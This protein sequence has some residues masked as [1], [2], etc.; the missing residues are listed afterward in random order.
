P[1]F[2][3]NCA[4][5]PSELV[6]S[7]LFGYERG[8]F[9]G[10][11]QSKPGMFALADGATLMLDEIGDM[12][13]NLQAKLLQVLQDQ[14]FRPLGAREFVRVDVR[15]IAATHC[16]L[17]AA[18]R[19]GRFREDL[20]YRLSVVILRVP[21]LRERQGEILE[22]A[23]YFLHK[24]AR[25]GMPAPKIGPVLAGALL[26]HHWPGNIRELENLMRRYLIFEDQERLAADLKVAAGAEAVRPAESLKIPPPAPP[27]SSALEGIEEA[28]SQAARQTILATLGS[29]RWN[30]KK[31]ARL[32]GVD[33]KALLYKM[34]KL[35]IVQPGPVVMFPETGKAGEQLD[36]AS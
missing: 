12:D 21:P 24:H 3:L 6:E 27:S 15:V 13:F 5:L 35:G 33:Y 9:T 26:D 19:Q 29:V 7:E 14:E 1:F 34:R 30:R 2:K 10:A 18:I 22:L 36:K 31:A 17:K 32:L 20:Y 8:A 16:D 4:A 11:A 28:R 23:R 25:P